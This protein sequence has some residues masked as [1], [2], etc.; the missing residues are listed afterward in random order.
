MI[1]AERYPLFATLVIFGITATVWMHAFATKTIR[2]RSEEIAILGLLFVVPAG[3]VSAAIWIMLDRR[4]WRIL[5]G[6]VLLV[7]ALGI[8]VLSLMLANAGFR[9]H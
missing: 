5:L 3:L 4:W 6:I 2:L 8:W 9:I 1:P 7:P